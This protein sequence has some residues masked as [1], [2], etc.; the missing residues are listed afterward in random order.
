DDGGKTRGHEGEEQLAHDKS[1]L[2]ATLDPTSWRLRRPY[3]TETLPAPPKNGQRTKSM[4]PDTTKTRI[5]G[6]NAEP[7]VNEPVHRRI[8]GSRRPPA[9]PSPRGMSA[10][11]IS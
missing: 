9:R 1:S 3:R 11:P 5:I 4:Q 8:R 10:S 2:L 7:K 6:A